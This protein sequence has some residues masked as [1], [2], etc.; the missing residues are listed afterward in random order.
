MWRIGD[1][2]A[3]LGKSW[4]GSSMFSGIGVDEDEWGELKNLYRRWILPNFALNRANRHSS[5]STGSSVG[6]RCTR[7]RCSIFSAKPVLCLSGES[8]DRFY[9][10][11]FS[12][13][14]IKLAKVYLKKYYYCFKFQ[15]YQSFYLTFKY[16]NFVNVLR[17]NSNFYES[18]FN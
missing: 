10:P 11:L 6:T 3:S 7:F 14:S 17:W 12:K 18:L 9:L 4:S 5:S 1:R 13:R 2:K 16:I 15:F 8:L